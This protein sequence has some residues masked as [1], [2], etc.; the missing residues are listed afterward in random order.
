MSGV[1]GSMMGGPL[2]QLGLGQIINPAATAIQWDI[3]ASMLPTKY[4]ILYKHRT[5][6]P[7]ISEILHAYM[8]AELDWNATQ[9][10][11]ALNGHS[12]QPDGGNKA[13]NTSGK[14]WNAIVA[15]ALPKM[16]VSQLLYCFYS[17][18][19]SKDDMAKLIKKYRIKEGHWEPLSSMLY[20]KFDQG[21]ILA[22][23]YRGQ[24]KEEET[25]KRLRRFYG[26]DEGHAKDVLEVSKFIPPP[27][28]LTRFA[29][30]DVFNKDP[31]ITDPL[32]VEFEENEGLR[33]WFRAQ[34]IEDTTIKDKN[35]QPFRLDIPMAYWMA[36]WNLPSPGQGY[37]FLHRLRPNR[38]GRWGN[39]VPGLTPF[40]VDDLSTLL[41]QDDY[42]SKYRP[43]LA[44]VSYSVPRL[45]DIR[46]MYQSEII[47]KQ[48]LIEKLQDRGYNESDARETADFYEQQKKDK[49]EAKDKKENAEYYGKLRSAIVEG[50]RVGSVARDIA[51]TALVGTD[52][53]IGVVI[54]M[55]NAVDI[56]VNTAKVKAL[57]DMTR[58][59]FFF[60]GMDGFEALGALIGGQVATPRATDHIQRWQRQM[61]LQRKA[62][63][64]H[65]IIEYV[66]DGRM[67]ANEARIRFSNLGY[68]EIDSLMMLDEALDKAAERRAKLDLQQAKSEEQARRA[69]EQMQKQ[70]QAQ[71]RAAIARYAAIVTLPRLEKWY[72]LGLMSKGEVYNTLLYVGWPQHE[73]QM[74]ID[75]LPDRTEDNGE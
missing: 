23:H 14:L 56:Q 57:I 43:L 20:A 52:L 22:S 62:L 50:Y 55:L 44:A 49:D 35:G 13:S 3:D 46:N 25:I 68:T 54:G 30:R 53:K 41:K 40:T 6:L 7:G 64:V 65:K 2:Y 45:I 74:A 60:G 33:E 58:K 69:A 24:W 32:K 71:A 8:G 39:S 61:T 48:E 75:A 66:T 29:V 70:Q 42:A 21:V 10:G 31:K 51:E 19:I 37:E 26:C 1:L 27:T 9:W 47:D 72:K 12:L 36:H 34:G 17:G 67:S 11:F 38:I 63:S 15:A 18:I 4:D 16:D 5:I 73:A 59:A 28:D